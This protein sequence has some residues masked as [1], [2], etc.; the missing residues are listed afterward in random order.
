MQVPDVD[1]VFH[2][3]DEPCVPTRVLGPNG[4]PA[5]PI[6]GYTATAGFADI[7][8]PDFSFW[9]HEHTR[10]R[11]EVLGFMSAIAFE[12]IVCTIP[13]DSIVPPN[14]IAHSYILCKVQIDFNLSG[15]D[16]G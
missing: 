2:I 14:P 12:R 1:A 5:P 8:F 7:P 3:S 11:G 15:S 10:M 6:F 9:G 13:C 16:L 4:E